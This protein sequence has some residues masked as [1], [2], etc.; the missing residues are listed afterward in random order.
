MWHYCKDNLSTQAQE[1]FYWIHDTF[2]CC[3]IKLCTKLHNTEPDICNPWHA[4]SIYFWSTDTLRIQ[5]GWLSMPIL[6]ITIVSLSQKPL[7]WYYRYR[8]ILSW[9]YHDTIRFSQQWSL[10]MAKSRKN[11]FWTKQLDSNC[12]YNVFALICLNVVCLLAVKMV[13][14]FD[15]Y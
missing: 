6:T 10:N 3:R 8:G 11:E 14:H 5:K 13:L 2:I 7:S 4:K 12:L 1:R 9:Y 15:Y